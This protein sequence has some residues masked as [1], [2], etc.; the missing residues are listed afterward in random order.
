MTPNTI[1]KTDYIEN[2][3]DN[4]KRIQLISYWQLQKDNFRNNFKI[5]TKPDVCV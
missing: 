3:G 2:I 4:T 1:V 5:T